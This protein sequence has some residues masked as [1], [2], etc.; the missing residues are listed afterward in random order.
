MRVREH[1]QRKGEL[2]SEEQGLQRQRHSR[3]LRRSQSHQEVQSLSQSDHQNPSPLERL[4]GPISMPS[5]L[6]RNL[7]YWIELE[8]SRDE[9]AGKHA[10]NH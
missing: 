2:S 4:F 3:L 1:G 8:S 6:Q 5:K 10:R 9:G 7:I